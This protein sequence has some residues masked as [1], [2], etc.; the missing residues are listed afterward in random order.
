MVLRALTEI[1]GYTRQFEGAVMSLES[2]YQ[3]IEYIGEH[4]KSAVERGTW[5]ERAVMFYL[6]NDPEM[7]QVIFAGI[8]RQPWHVT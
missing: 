1:F 5:W 6:R 8:V 4:A 7:R 3:V 2:V